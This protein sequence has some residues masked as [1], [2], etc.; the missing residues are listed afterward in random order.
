MARLQYRPHIR[1]CA[2]AQ[3]EHQGTIVCAIIRRPSRRGICQCEQE[4]DAL[5]KP[6]EDIGCEPVVV[7]L[8]QAQRPHENLEHD[9]MVIRRMLNVTAI[10]IDLAPDLVFD[11]TLPSYPPAFRGAKLWKQ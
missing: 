9:A 3:G 2:I 1:E 4:A 10:A 6:I 8:T 11:R 5:A 7:S